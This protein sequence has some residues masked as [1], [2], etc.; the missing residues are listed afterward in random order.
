MHDYVFGFEGEIGVEMLKQLTKEEMIAFYKKTFVD[1]ESC[2]SF[3]IHVTPEM[4][5]EEQKKE[6]LKRKEENPDLLCF[7]SHLDFIKKRGMVQ[8]GDYTLF[9]VPECPYTP[10]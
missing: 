9:K 10:Y 7:N 3:E 1:Q 6:F 5:L 8:H 2:Q 4:H